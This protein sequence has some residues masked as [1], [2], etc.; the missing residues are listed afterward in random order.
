MKDR[1]VKLSFSYWF[2]VKYCLAVVAIFAVANGLLYLLLNKSLAGGYRESLQT[3]YYLDQNLSTYLSIMALLLIL[4]IL[5]LTL[6]VT[7]LISHQI[8]GPVFR[9]EAALKNI[10]SGNL[11]KDIATRQTDQLKPLVGSINDLTDRC[12][13]TFALAQKISE[14]V[15][16]QVV[17]V[18][19]TERLNDLLKQVA[20]ARRQMVDFQSERFPE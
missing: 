7:L 4:F 5:I 10:I 3:L 20:D 17:S 19:E 1:P 14:S 8:A 11:S 2:Q 16:E 12:R 18:P 15:E 9:Y 6:V 13:K